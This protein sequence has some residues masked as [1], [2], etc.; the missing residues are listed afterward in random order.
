MPQRPQG[1]DRAG[2][3]DVVALDG[4]DQLGPADKAGPRI[5]PLEIGPGGALRCERVGLVL[6]PADRDPRHPMPS[7][8]LSSSPPRK[9]GSGEAERLSPWILACAG[10]TGT[11]PRRPPTP[12]PNRGLGLRRSLGR[13]TGGRRRGRRRRLRAVRRRAGGGL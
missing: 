5:G 6:E 8:M 10:M 3:R 7:L 13:P 4:I 11:V 2:N 1:L 9:R 12:R